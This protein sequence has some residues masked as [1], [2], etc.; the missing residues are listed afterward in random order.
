MR[1]SEPIF[2]EPPGVPNPNEGAPITLANCIQVG[3]R[4]CGRS[5]YLSR[6]RIHDIDAAGCKTFG[7]LGNKLRCYECYREGGLGKN[8]TLKIIEDIKY[9]ENL[10]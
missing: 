1:S 9:K 4:D 2:D 3:C 6:S 5:V 10:Q 8:I 7:A